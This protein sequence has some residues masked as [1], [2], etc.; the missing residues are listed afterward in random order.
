MGYIL[1]FKKLAILFIYIS[2][3]IPLLGFPSTNPLSP[4][5]LFPASMRMLPPMIHPFPPHH[6]S[7]LY[8]GASHLHRTKGLPSHRCRIRQSSA[9]YTAGAMGFSMCILVLGLNVGI[10]EGSGWLIWL[11]FQWGCRPLH[12]LHSFAHRSEELT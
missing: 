8:A 9:T 4:P 5:T 7:I 11:F 12:F 3:V 2:N 1:L 10:S 6:P